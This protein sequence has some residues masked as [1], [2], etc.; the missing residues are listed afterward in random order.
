MHFDFSYDAETVTLKAK[1]EASGLLSR[2]R[3]KSKQPNLSAL[4]SAER[5][6]AFAIADLRA[7]ADTLSEP[8]HITDHTIELTHR[9]A[10]DIDSGMAKILGLPPLVD[11]ILRTDAEGILGSTS[12]RLRY[13]WV[14]DGQKIF[15]KRMGAILSLGAKVYRVPL[16]ML[17]ALDIADGHQAAQGDAT[18]WG[19]LAK[20]RQALDPG[21]SA[22]GGATKAARASLTDFLSGLEVRLADAFSISPRDGEQFDI[23]PFS[24]KRLTDEGV[25]TGLVAASESMGELAGQ[26]LRT[27]QNRVRD[28]GALAAYR[29]SPASYLVI[30]KA[31]APALAVMARMQHATAAQRKAFIQNP[32]ALITE[33]VEQSLRANGKLDGLTAVAEEE[34]IEAAAGPLLVETQEFSERVTGIVAYQKMA[35]AVDASSGTTWLPENFSRR[36][37]EVLAPLSVERLVELKNKVATAVEQRAEFVQHED[38]PLPA[39]PEM[40]SLLEEK[41]AERQ[42]QAGD[43][44]V[45]QP[46]VIKGPIVLETEVNFEDLNWHAKLEPRAASIAAEVPGSIRTAL[47]DHQKESF[48]WQVAAWKSGLPGILNADEQGLGKT[49]QTICFLAWLKEHM[50]QAGADQRGPVLVVAPTSLLENWEQEVRIHMHEPG[51]GHVIRLYGANMAGRKQLGAKGK[52]IDD[53]SAKLELGFL[54]DAIE[55]GRAH[56]FWILTTYTTLTN[57]QHSLGR[58]RFSAAVFDEIQAIKNPASL[59][60]V[61]ARSVNADFRIGL[62]GTPI[63]NTTVDLW[64]IMDQLA[65][66]S[67]GTLKDFRSKY[68][69][70]NADNMCELYARTFL[71]VDGNPPLALRRM[72]DTVAKDLPEK[73]RIVS[74]GVV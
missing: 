14:R 8:L 38:L 19:A 35:L 16:W 71:K 48:Q 11:F 52:D 13:E 24:G 62:T 3:G 57:F 28:R 67:L 53:G 47:K 2:L 56:R 23:V 12:F 21:I 66:G 51:L 43:K 9:L 44:D 32:Q 61:G 69:Q 65:A 34:A 73:V 29:M 36:L 68:S 46:E 4:A 49:L 17:E 41:I 59:R 7:Q 72:K 1:G 42:L 31:A 39:R 26:E 37:Q 20:F 33:A 45:V 30:D 6:I 55:E 70:P 27:F 54:H 40:V 10:A 22:A 18:D 60:A 58:I 64:A 15:P 25:D 5:D 74:Q 63:E 50:E